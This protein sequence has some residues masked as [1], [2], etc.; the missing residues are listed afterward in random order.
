MILIDKKIDEPVFIQDGYVIIELPDFG[1]RITQAVKRQKG[2]GG[3]NIISK[4]NPLHQEVLTFLLNWTDKRWT[5]KE[6]H[7]CI[8]E[9]RTKKNLKR[10]AFSSIQGRV[11]ELQYHQAIVLIKEPKWYIVNAERAKEILT[12]NSFA[13]DNHIMRTGVTQ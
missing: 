12:K 8:N 5:V 11:S 9:E 4:P 10:W 6:L 2:T 7:F 3:T 1:L 13:T